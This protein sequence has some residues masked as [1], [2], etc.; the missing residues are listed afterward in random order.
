MNKRFLS[1]E[2][3]QQNTL[4]R[5][6]VLEDLTS[7]NNIQQQLVSLV[8]TVDLQVLTE[9]LVVG[10]LTELLV[11]GVLTKLL[12]VGALIELLTVGVDT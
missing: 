8:L 9:L 2:V 5:L 7:K 12:V 10:V 11:V 3:A 4:K 1:V 6:Q